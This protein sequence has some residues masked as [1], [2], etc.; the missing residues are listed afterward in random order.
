VVAPWPDI[1]GRSP[2][3]AGRS[4]PG[5]GIS[6]QAELSSRT[7]L[8]VPAE[9]GVSTKIVPAKPCSTAARETDGT[10][11]CVGIPSRR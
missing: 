3:I 11:T 9:D 4:A 5:Q 1:A 7:G 6:P 2:P 10:T 8:A